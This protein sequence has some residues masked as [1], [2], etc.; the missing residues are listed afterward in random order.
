MSNRAKY[1]VG[2]L[3]V[4]VVLLALPLP[5]WLKVLTVIGIPVA[6]YLA[7]DPGQRRRLR[8]ITRKQIGR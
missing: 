6:G 8:G 4:F 7:L 2:A 5:A 3:V 1:A